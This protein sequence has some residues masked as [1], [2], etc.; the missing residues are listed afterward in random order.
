M[1]SFSQNKNF[2]FFNKYSEKWKPENNHSYIYDCK[3]N[4]I[5]IDK[6]T[7]NEIINFIERN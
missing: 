3:K 1:L 5:T 7:S 2:L 4:N 6:I